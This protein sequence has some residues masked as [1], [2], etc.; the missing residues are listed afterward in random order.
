M[1]VFSRFHVEDPSAALEISLKRIIIDLTWVWLQEDHHIFLDAKVR[2]AK[3]KD[4]DVQQADHRTLAEL[5][6]EDLNGLEVDA[7]RI[8]EEERISDKEVKQA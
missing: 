4:L 1:E 6:I 5:H 3:R 2:L 7:I 8:E